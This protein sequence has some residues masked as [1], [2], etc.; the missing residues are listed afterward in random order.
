MTTFS[1]QFDITPDM[2]FDVETDDINSLLD[3]YSENLG[4]D[5][6]W[7]INHLKGAAQ[8]NESGQYVRTVVNSTG[9]V[10]V[11]PEPEKEAGRAADPW[12]EETGGVLPDPWGG[13]STVRQG[14][15]SG[16]QIDGTVVVEG[17]PEP[18]VDGIRD[19]F[20]RTW[21]AG[22]DGAPM[23]ECPEGQR[24]AKVKGKTR[25]GKWYTA[26]KC[27]KDMP[28][29]DYRNKCNFTEYIN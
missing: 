4:G 2:S 28:G 25:A 18:Q 12:A 1:L 15:T 20:G 16:A 23:C 21:K 29:G 13:G 11:R 6:Q 22:V 8:G 7:L 5:A 3:F 26:W 19:K 24:A 10:P 14:L 17:T 27:A 9:G